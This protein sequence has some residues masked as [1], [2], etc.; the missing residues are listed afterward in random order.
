MCVGFLLALG[1]VIFWHIERT[2]AGT[3]RSAGV[4]TKSGSSVSQCVQCHGPVMAARDLHVGLDCSACH[5]GNAEAIE[6][7]AAHQGMIRI[8]GNLADA[9]RTCGVCHA[10]EV[11]DIHHSLMTTNVGIVAVDRFVFGEQSTPDGHTPITEIGH[12]AADDHLRNL[13]ASCHLGQEKVDFGPIDD[14]SRGGGCN[15]CHLNFEPDTLRE[16]NHYLADRSMIPRSHPTLDLEI[17]DT[18]CLGCHSRSGRIAMNYQGFHETQLTEIP[19]GESGSSRYRQLQDGRVFTFVEADVHHRMGLACVDCHP[20][21]D[22]MG[23]GN[24]YTHESQ[25]V[26]VRCEDCHLEQPETARGVAVDELPELYQRIHRV[27]QFSHNRVLTTSPGDV[28]LVNTYL[29]G[30]GKAY[31]YGKL[32]HSLHEM[33]PPSAACSREFAHRDL[34]CSACHTR[35][36]PQCVQCHTRYDSDVAGYDLLENRERMGAWIE[37]AG[38]LR[39]GPPTLGVYEWTET[40]DTAIEGAHDRIQPAVPGMI[41][42]LDPRGF[43]NPKQGSSETGDDSATPNS[44]SETFHRLFAPAAPHTIAAKGRDCRSCHNDPIA[45]GYGAGELVYTIGDRSG[46][47][48]FTPADS[49]RLS[50]GL[51]ND[52]WIG[53]LQEPQLVNSTRLNFRPFTVAQ[54]K[55]ILRVG[56]CLECH[57]QNAARMQ[58]TLN[59]DFERQISLLPPSCVLPSW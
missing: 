56:A 37:T 47:W 8:P 3:L 16:L 44:S 27:R 15:A 45:L 10:Q 21:A 26:H 52:A 53:F 33:K 1:W 32:D 38:D 17:S 40:L 49:S 18:H 41:L 43:E 57:E 22:V 30:D 35:W 28:P 2:Q 42:T 13:C 5:L 54:Q 7:D 51:A 34:S 4:A 58:E 6:A 12:S 36:A 11:S 29:P 46:N 20:Y 48:S 55:R 59:A 23:D 19:V 24:S 31:L 14:A 39:A 25:A 50:D 9:S